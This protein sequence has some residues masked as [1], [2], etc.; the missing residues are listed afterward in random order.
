MPETESFKVYGDGV[1]CGARIFSLESTPGLGV[2]Y[3]EHVKSRFRP[4]KRALVR[5]FF[6]VRKTER[7]F[8]FLRFRLYPSAML[9]ENPRSGWHC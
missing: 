3:I 8:D 6:V 2:P 7:M 4:Q 9:F 5:R 1:W